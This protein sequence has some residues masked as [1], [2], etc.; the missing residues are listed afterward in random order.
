MRQLSAA[1]EFK[2]YILVAKQ[3][4]IMSLVA[5]ISFFFSRSR[6]TG[7]TESRYLSNLLL[8][9]ISPCL[10]FSTFDIR[11]DTG[12]MKDIAIMMAVALGVQILLTLIAAAS[13]RS[14]TETGKARDPFDKMAVIYS[15]AGFIGIPLINGV[16]GQPG[17]FLLMG[18]IVVY[19]F[20]L[21]TNGIF[22]VTHKISIKQIVTNPNIIAI[23]AGMLL[24]ILPVRLPDI[25]SQTVRLVGDLNTAVSMILLGILFANFKKPVRGEKSPAFRIA[26]TTVLRLIVSPLILLAFLW[27]VGHVLVTGTDIRRTLM[28]L[29]IASSCPAGMCI[30]N[31]AVLYDSKNESYGSLLVSVSSLLCVV[32]IPL[33]ARL[34]DLVL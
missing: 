32:T 1:A 11:F 7:E 22:L 28:I 12:K 13:I 18:Y 10:I 27:F 21:W 33:L 5:V 4:L 20:Y 14:R 19:N 31:F 30:A 29:F 23:F 2:M 16:F 17:V 6:K 8:F 34:A 3:L 26:K 24:F 15:N 9:V 25:I